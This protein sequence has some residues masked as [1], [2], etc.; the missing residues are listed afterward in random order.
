MNLVLYIFGN[1]KILFLPSISCIAAEGGGGRGKKGVFLVI[2][3]RGK[4]KELR[5]S[6]ERQ[7]GTDM[8]VSGDV[9]AIVHKK[10]FK[11]EKAEAIL[12]Q[13][14]HFLYPGLRKKR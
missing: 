12:R 10:H 9:S 1:W 13:S 6:R 5:D 4:A 8:Q 14:V 11:K 7:L 3:E 2:F